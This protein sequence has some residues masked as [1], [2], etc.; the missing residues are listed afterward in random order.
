MKHLRSVIAVFLLAAALLSAGC[1]THG[2]SHA[3]VRPY[4]LDKCIVLDEPLE[5]GK[6]RTFVYKGQEIKVCCKDCVADFHKDP[7][8]YMAK[9]NA[10][11]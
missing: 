3:S 11:R 2:G 7:D 1:A 5:A 6:G 8:K 4:P 9:I 10:A